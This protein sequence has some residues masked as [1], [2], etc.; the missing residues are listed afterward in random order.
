MTSDDEHSELMAAWTSVH[1]L[2]DRMTPSLNLDA[3]GL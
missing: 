3:P 2:L 1:G